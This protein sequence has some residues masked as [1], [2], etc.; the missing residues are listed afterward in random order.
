[1]NTEQQPD[2]TDYSRKKLEEFRILADRFDG[3]VRVAPIID[4]RI[5]FNANREEF[6]SPPLLQEIADPSVLDRLCILSDTLSRFT[7]DRA[8]RDAE[9][10]TY[11]SETGD[12]AHQ[13]IAGDTED[14]KRAGR[15]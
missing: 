7:L 3:D 12:I 2:F 4:G 14:N 9:V 6:E 5:C 15:A 1:M 10:I 11:L 13:Q 8:D